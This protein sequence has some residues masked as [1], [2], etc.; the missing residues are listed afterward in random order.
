MTETAKRDSRPAPSADRPLA[1]FWGDDA[2]GLESATDL[3]RTR[4]TEQLGSPPERW[5]TRGDGPSPA[6]TIALLTERLATGSMFGAGT[7]AVVTGIGPL[8]K[9][10]EDR[11]AF[12]GLFPRI[13]PGNGLIVLEETESGRKDAPHRPVVEAITE[14]GGTVHRF[15][16]PTAG[17]LSAWI[18]R[19]AGE[20]GLTLE[21]GAARELAGRVGGFVT[22]NDV[23]RRRQGQ[24]AA[25]ELDKLAL[26]RPDGSI[27]AADVQ[28][29]VP[30]AVP[31]SVWAFTDAVGTR[32]GAQ[33]IRLLERLLEITP[34]PVL[35]AV[36]H[37]R[38]RELLE[39][40]SRL[41]AGETDG[42]LVRVMKLHPYRAGELIRQA[43]SWQESELEEAL[44][45]LV[46]LDATVKGAP[47]RP[48]GDAQHRLAFTLWVTDRVMRSRDRAAL[49]V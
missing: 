26:Y 19:Q 36:L 49:R 4:M 12:V 33:A 47:G 20:R 38:I 43:R 7:L 30:E 11:E 9:R 32:N 10:K 25:M 13:A 2:F 45:A 21:P 16:A 42:S 40:A 35:L 23:D 44:G 27:S 3:V 18:G 14:H 6:T 29:L 5:R 8:V 48:V 15:Q 37:R 34:E 24:I 1:F 31:G 41:S 39:V 22:E 46:E 28:A 17:G